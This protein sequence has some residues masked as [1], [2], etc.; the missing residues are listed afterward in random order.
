MLEC[1][2]AQKAKYRWKQGEQLDPVPMRPTTQI[3]VEEW[4]GGV[5]EGGGEER[6]EGKATHQTSFIRGGV[7]GVFRNPPTQD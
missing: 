1:E 4:K 6:R 2:A 5:G 3:S 7:R